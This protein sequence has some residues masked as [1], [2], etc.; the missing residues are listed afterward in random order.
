[1]KLKQRLQ[2][3]KTA[4]V[5]KSINTERWGSDYF[6][7]YGNGFNTSSLLV[8]SQQLSDAYRKCPIIPII[9][10]KRIN[11]LTNGVIKVL[12]S[13]GEEISNTPY[14]KFLKNPNPLQSG[15]QYIAQVNAITTYYGYCP[16]LRIEPFKNKVT[17]CYPLMPEYLDIRFRSAVNGIGAEVN[18]IY[19]LIESI[20]F[21]YNGESTPLDKYDIYFHTDD[22][23]GMDSMIFPQ[24]KI[25]PCYN[26]VSNLIRNYEARSVLIQSH[27]A[28]GIL[29]ND[30]KDAI[31]T[32]PQDQQAK[33]Q[34]QQDYQSYGL[35]KNQWKIIITSLS[36]KWQQMSL[37]ISDLMLFENEKA[38]I[39]I[40]A[41]A[42]GYPYKLLGIA[43]DT[44][45]DNQ[46]QLKKTLYSD[47]I[48]PNAQYMFE[49]LNECIKS[50]TNGYTITIDFSHLSIFQDDIQ[51]KA[52]AMALNVR[53]G[54]H[55]FKN[56]F[57]NYDEVVKL[58]GYNT[59][60]SQLAGKYWID[61]TDEQRMLFDDI[62]SSI[63]GTQ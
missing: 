19:D 11:A 8:N 44:S 58:L 39:Q 62:G 35:S 30:G 52:K 31:G 17:R 37:P 23:V 47:I 57:I 21:T 28:L 63:N 26:Q 40:I 18:D 55:A 29:S 15:M 34:L 43:E 3:I 42:L 24:A 45:Y 56:N 25:T 27:G 10:N 6:I 22:S 61:L 41:D 53:S 7:P 50:Q 13:K 5:G 36:L 14:N 9:I 33:E 60:N 54:V 12:N 32:L 2:L 38:D 51:D 4:I 59:F 20:T 1:M 46:R 49:Q 48:I 16:I